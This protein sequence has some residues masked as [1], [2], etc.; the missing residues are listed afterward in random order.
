MQ[1]VCSA[2]LGHSAVNTANYS[3]SRWSSAV[4]LRGLKEESHSASHLLSVR[5]AVG[6]VLFGSKVR[7][8]S[9]LAAGLFK[10]TV[11]SVRF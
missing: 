4:E 10:A 5:A 1:A 6:K 7:L 9:S 8:P 11:T 3:S 2:A